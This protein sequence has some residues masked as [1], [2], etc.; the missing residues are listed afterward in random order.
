MKPV[1]VGIIGYGYW[2][3]NL[4]RNFSELPSTEV[5]AIA[6]LNPAQL[7]RVRLRYPKIACL[8][9]YRHFFEMGVEAVIVATPP[10]THYQIAR[11]C[12]EHG[13]HALVEKPLALHTNHVKHLIQIAEEQDR[14]LM[15]G[16]T[17]EYN[18]TVRALKEIIDSGELGEIFYIDAVRTNLGLYQ[19]HINVM[20]DLAPHD[21]SILLYLLNEEPC[22]VRA[23]GGSFV[24]RQNHDVA[25][26]NLDFPSGKL[27][28][29]HVS[30]INPNKV[31]Y[32]TVVGSKK[33]AVYNDIET[34]ERIK[35]Y[36]KG[37]NA[38][39]YTDSFGD[40]QFSYRYG[41]VVSPHIDFTEPLHVE[42]RHFV[43]CIVN[44]W[45]PQT[46]GYNGLRVVKVLEA[47]EQALKSES[48][49]VNAHPKPIPVHVMTSD[50]VNTGTSFPAH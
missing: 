11:D 41:N 26:I 32:I 46:D 6:D 15:V 25:Y 45:Q 28:H 20:W 43:D 48:S 5:V 16:H 9:D 27:A 40:F 37:V 3:P 33:M 50:V 10:H 24:M 22:A 35:I 36:D 1:K 4:V 19:K 31:R 42:A 34:V 29:I 30:W 38:P 14:V 7:D 8:S 44:H 23:S 13:L 47:A 49:M 18:S 39:P 12:L 17:F 2:G 21:I